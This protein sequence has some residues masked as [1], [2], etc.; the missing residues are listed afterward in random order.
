VENAKA[1]I[2]AVAKAKPSGAKGTYMKKISL[3]ATMT[4]GVSLDVAEAT[5]QD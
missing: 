3:T 1:F 4:P 5:A 2:D